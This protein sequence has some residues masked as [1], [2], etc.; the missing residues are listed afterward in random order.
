MTWLPLHAGGSRVPILSNVSANEFWGAKVLATTHNNDGD[1]DGKNAGPPRILIV[2]DEVLV[3]MFAVDALE[4]AGFQVDQAANGAEA[5]ALLTKFV[6]EISAVVIDLGLPDR[7][8]DEVAT[9]MRTIRAD[10]P[11]LIASGRSEKELRERFTLTGRVGVMVK[12][13]TGP[14]L[15]AALENIGVHGAAP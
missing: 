14:M 9:Q 8:G 13:F 12:P 11:I 15:V 6:N 4:D 2:E 5:L 7:P 1:N 3:R 10:V